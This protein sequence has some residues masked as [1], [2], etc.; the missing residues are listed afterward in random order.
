MIVTVHDRDRGRP[1]SKYAHHMD[2]FRGDHAAPS[3]LYKNL[4]D[5][6]DVLSTRD[7]RSRRARVSLMLLSLR[8][9][10]EY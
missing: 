8:I 6:R 10:S 4:R 3:R 1:S 2:T 5:L 9:L 7:T